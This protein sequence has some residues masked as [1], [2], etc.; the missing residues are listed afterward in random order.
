V[1]ASIIWNWAA[2]ASVSSLVLG[3]VLLVSL[4]TYAPE[5][6]RQA[7]RKGRRLR[8]AASRGR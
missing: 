2:Q 1:S 5:R 6:I 4:S 8:A 3:I 7:V